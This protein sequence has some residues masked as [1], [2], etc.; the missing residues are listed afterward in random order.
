ME[1]RWPSEVHT[2]LVG[3]GM[4]V[5]AKGSGQMG[6]HINCVRLGFHK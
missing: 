4:A 3:E 1:R 6:R 2:W 5:A